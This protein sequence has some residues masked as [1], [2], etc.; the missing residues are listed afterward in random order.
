[1]SIY[2][3]DNGA[4]VRV[5]NSDNNTVINYI[6]STLV[7]QKDNNDSFFLK[8]D[9]FINYYRY[10]NV[11][12]PSTG[13]MDELITMLTSWNTPGTISTTFDSS[14]MDMMSQLKVSSPKVV[15][16]SLQNLFDS[17]PLK[18]DELT[19]SSA[20][21]TYNSNQNSVNMNLIATTGSRIVRQSKLYPT[22]IHGTTSFAYV[23]G[24][25][26]TNTTNSNVV[27]KIGLFDDSNDI[28]NGVGGNGVFFKYDNTS[29]LALVYRTNYGGSQ[30]DYIV[31]QSSWNIDPLNGSGVSGQTLNVSAV[32]DYIFEWH[33][34]SNS[35]VVRAG[36]FGNG[37]KYAHAFSNMPLFGNPC[38]P[39]RWE[40]G[41]DSNLGSANSATMVQ[42]PAT[43]YTDTPYEGPYNIF[44][45]HRSQFVSLTTPWCVHPLMS[46][47]LQAPYERSKLI[48]SEIE[49]LNIA[50]GGVGQWSL[51]LN[52]S[53]NDP[54]WQT[55][56]QSS[57]ETDMNST[58]IS[59]GRVLASGYFYDAGVTKISLTDKDI[60]LLCSINGTQDVLT[61]VI[62]LVNG[63]L[64]ISNTLTWKE[65]D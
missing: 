41:H 35:N 6:K 17:S 62:K 56:S 15:Q 31:P 36:I 33:Q 49:L 47:R 42:G 20:V 38:L 3:Y 37:L 63:A 27:S 34:V 44:G 4:Y 48:P 65:R 28:V 51:V 16:L 40:I 13:N 26:T 64:N 43:V 22:N 18:I 19:A 30:A 2:I 50:P 61:F 59:G 46:I 52:G 14:M 21:S 24:I 57:A 5:V 55:V 60:E 53:L 39:V 25:L 7:I 9:S 1:M 45:E 29:N 12:T 23:N 10:C 32:T 54:S 8:N 11:A 58:A